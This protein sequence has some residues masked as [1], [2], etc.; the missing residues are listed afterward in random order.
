MDRT[1]LVIRV[2]VLGVPVL[3][4]VHAVLA[5]AID[6]SLTVAAD[7]LADAGAHENLG[8]GHARRAHAAE[9]HLQL[10]RLLI[11]DSE[12]VDQRGEH[13]DRGA[14]LIVVEDGYLYF[15][16]QTILDFEA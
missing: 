12:R 13:D 16:L 11:D 9:D 14:V 3:H 8:A 5:A 15:T 10:F 2:G 6:R 7:D 4:E 1:A